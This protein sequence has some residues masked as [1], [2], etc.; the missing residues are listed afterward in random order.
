M[1]IGGH[2]TANKTGTVERFLVTNNGITNLGMGPHLPYQIQ[3]AGTA[4]HPTGEYV[5]VIGGIRVPTN[6]AIKDV[7]MYDVKCSSWSSMPS[8]LKERSNST[9]YILE[10]MLYVVGG[11]NKYGSSL[12]DMECLNITKKGAEWNNVTL[13]YQS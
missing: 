11:K 2:Y 9:A 6:E 10:N 1:V 5:Y 8:L 13:V 3:W 12:S 7:W 4:V